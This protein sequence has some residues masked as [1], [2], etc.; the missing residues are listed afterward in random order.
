[1]SA[2]IF[3]ELVHLCA[4]CHVLSTLAD[5]VATVAVVAIVFAAH[6]SSLMRN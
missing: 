1:M 6:C 3:Q 2:G 4:A 5:A